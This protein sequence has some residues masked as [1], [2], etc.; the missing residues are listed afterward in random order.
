MS[1]YEFEKYIATKNNVV[2][3][4]EKYGVAIIPNILDDEECEQMNKGMWDTLEFMTQTWDTPIDRCNPETWREMQKLYPTHSM[5]IQHW[6]IGHAQYV[7]DIRQ[8]PKVVD[9]YSEIW[10][11]PKEDLLVSFDAVSY[12]LPPE[13]TR[14]GWYRGH[15]WFHSDQ[16]YL[17]SDFR[18]IQGWVTGYSVNEGDA[19]LAFLESSNQYHKDF[20]DTFQTTEK[21][22][23]YKLNDT[24]LAFYSDR[25]CLHKRI[26][27]PKGSLVLWDSRTI[28]CGSQALKTREKPNYRNVAYVCY[29]PREKCTKLKKKREAFENMRLTTHWPCKVKLFNKMPRT[30]GKE[31]HYPTQLP[32]PILNELGRRLA[33]F[34]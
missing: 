8:N 5:L 11:C 1:E 33:G 30:Y 17:N 4:V 3:V 24:E 12:H 18:C 25:G 28:H 20:Q 16:S 6:S 26:K 7:W 22:D 10:K 21:D 13:E 14:I 31:V 2:E 23:W 34:D 15:D 29:E 27:C 19:T 32:Q 9:I